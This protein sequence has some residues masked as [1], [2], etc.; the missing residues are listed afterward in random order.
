MAN[1]ASVATQLSTFLQES[2]SF[3]Q[4]ITQNPLNQFL[5]RI[6]NILII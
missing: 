4:V 1:N 6:T 5:K 2:N 3:K